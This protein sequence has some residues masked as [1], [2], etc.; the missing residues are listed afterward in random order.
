LHPDPTALTTLPFSFLVVNVALEFFHRNSTGVAGH[1]NTFVSMIALPIH[2]DNGR[3]LLASIR[4]KL[5][6][7]P[8]DENP[9]YQAESARTLIK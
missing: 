6:T 1:V 3:F 2:T 4:D 9:T 5:G 8:Q 7:G